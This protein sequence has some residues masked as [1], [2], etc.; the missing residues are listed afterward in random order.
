MVAESRRVV[1]R[2]STLLNCA[3]EKLW[4]NVSG[5]TDD[6]ERAWWGKFVGITISSKMI[7]T[8]PAGTLRRGYFKKVS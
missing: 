7:D 1:P 2:K 4:R 5:L 6:G 8:T 3:L